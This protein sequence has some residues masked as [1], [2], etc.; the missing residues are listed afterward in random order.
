MLGLVLVFFACFFLDP[1]GNE[2]ESHIAL[3]LRFFVMSGNGARDL[4][5]IP[6]FLCPSFAVRFSPSHLKLPPTL[7]AL[8][9]PLYLAYLCTLPYTALATH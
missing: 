3:A 7:R 4:P 8:I 1:V 5:E 9:F 6:S 2:E